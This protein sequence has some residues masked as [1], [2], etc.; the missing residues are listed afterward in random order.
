MS[1]FVKDQ[2]GV[3]YNR[4]HIVSAHPDGRGGFE[5]V[6]AR[7]GEPM[8]PIGEEALF[9]PDAVSWTFLP[10][11]PGTSFIFPKLEKG[12]IAYLRFAVVAWGLNADY[13]ALPFGFGDVPSDAVERDGAVEFADG[14]V[15][16]RDSSFPDLS[17]FLFSIAPRLARDAERA[18]ARKRAKLASR[19]ANS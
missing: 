15:E 7:G 9:G 14:H 5:I 4:A 3:R 1:S 8:T 16:F 17:A 18:A 12:E 10:A 2:S 13:G 19:R 6:T 11:A